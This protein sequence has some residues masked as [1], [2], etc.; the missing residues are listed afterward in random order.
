MDTQSQTLK[1]TIKAISL[2]EEVFLKI[3]INK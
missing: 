1:H 3:C 2:N